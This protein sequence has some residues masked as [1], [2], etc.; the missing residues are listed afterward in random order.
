[1]TDLTRDIGS[2]ADVAA[3]AG[4]ANA[5]AAGAGAGAPPL[6]LWVADGPGGRLAAPVKV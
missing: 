1:M 2:D 3:L 5:A 4:R 6:T